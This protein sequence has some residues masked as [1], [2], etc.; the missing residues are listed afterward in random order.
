MSGRDDA[1]LRRE[2]GSV[3]FDAH[4]TPDRKLPCC[5]VCEEDELFAGATR[6]YCY[7]CTWTSPEFGELA[8]V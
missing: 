8:P 1:L 5:P 6:F 4:G 3:R 2:L 7:R